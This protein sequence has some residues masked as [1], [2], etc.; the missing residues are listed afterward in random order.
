MSE[1]EKEEEAKDEAP[2]EQPGLSFVDRIVQEAMTS[3]EGLVLAPGEKKPRKIKPQKS[4]SEP[5][6]EAQARVEEIK[7]TSSV[8]EHSK[9]PKSSTDKLLADPVEI[10]DDFFDIDLDEEEPAEE[11]V[12]EE[13]AA[14]EPEPIVEDAAEEGPE[15]E[16]VVEDAPAEQPEA[17][18]TA[19][20]TEEPEPVPEN[21]KEEPES[22]PVTA[23]ATEKHPSKEPELLD[24]EVFEEP[25]TEEPAPESEPSPEPVAK[26]PEPLTEEVP[27]E[28]PE[29]DSTAEATEQPELALATEESSEERATEE[30]E[31]ESKPSSEPFARKAEPEPAPEVFR[32]RPGGDLRSLEKTLEEAAKP[33]GPK[34]SANRAASILR[35]FCSTIGAT[36]RALLVTE[37]SQGNFDCVAA[38]GFEG[39]DYLE[40]T[41]ARLLRKVWLTRDPILFIDAIKDPRCLRDKQIQKNKVRSVLCARIFDSATQTPG[42]VYLDDPEKPGSFS[43]QDLREAELICRSLISGDFVETQPPEP[44][45]KKPTESTI[46][47]QEATSLLDPRLYI[48]LAVVA[49]I[50]MI[51]SISHSLKKEPAPPPPVTKRS[52]RPERVVNNFLRSIRLGKEEY[53]YALLTEESRALVSLELF[54]KKSKKV[55]SQLDLAGEVTIVELDSP[56]NNETT[57]VL[58]V[59]PSGWQV[60]LKTQADVWKVDQFSGLV[61]R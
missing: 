42:L 9:R 19:E 28:Q 3:E 54:K 52:F 25:A 14:E 31:P 15:S 50:V 10:T 29:T 2:E 38:A 22:A 37:N 47:E 20:V 40:E 46:S 6:Q 56:E 5:D 7:D 49:A 18:S 61:Q 4:I 27:E 8:E 57:R 39:P 55:K 26:K 44:P 13:P 11:P 48:A 59:K 32:T 12:A 60:I 43:R 51:P 41:S 35:A 23:E 34:L 17:E 30:P 53:A 36:R 58:K 21:R 1:P 33:A 45:P 16:P 24:E